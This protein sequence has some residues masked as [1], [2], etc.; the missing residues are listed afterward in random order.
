MSKLMQ[1]T[2]RRRGTGELLAEG[3]AAECAQMLGWTCDEFRSMR[4]RSARGQSDY[5]IAHTEPF[6]STVP[7]AWAEQWDAAFGWLRTR[8]K[9]CRKQNPCASCMNR[10]VCDYSDQHCE[11]WEQYFPAAYDTTVA[12]LKK[13]IREQMLKKMEG[14]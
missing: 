5:L 13:R 1:F 14:W 12:N 4:V 2:V 9:V 8:E 7:A 3:G 6:N 10:A 11:S